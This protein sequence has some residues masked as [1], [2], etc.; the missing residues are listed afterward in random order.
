LLTTAHSPTRT[1][2]LLLDDVKQLHAAST[3][4]Q[5][6]NFR[7]R[8]PWSD[9][10]FLNKVPLVIASRY[11]QDMPLRFNDE[12]AN[13]FHGQ[14]RWA[15]VRSISFAQATMLE[16]ELVILVFTVFHY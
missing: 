4:E 10:W 2:N 9:S 6:E 13:H 1:I 12:T 8:S 11:G 7:M 14:S 16:Y 15:E 3:I 5:Y